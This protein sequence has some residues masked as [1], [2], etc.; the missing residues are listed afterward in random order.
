MISP[1][2]I[3]IS[4]HFLSKTKEFNQLGHLYKGTSNHYGNI[5]ENIVAFSVVHI[6]ENILKD[7][8]F[9]VWILF[10]IF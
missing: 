8:S 5:L 4:L 6:Q 2:I 10:G 9:Q 7:R 1:R 3:D